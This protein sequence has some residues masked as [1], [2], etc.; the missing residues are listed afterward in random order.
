MSVSSYR[1]VCVEK[2]SINS[3]ALNENP[4][5]KHQRMLVAG[6]VS[7]SATGTRFKN[8][9]QYFW[10]TMNHVPGRAGRNSNILLSPV[11]LSAGARILLKDTTIMP[12]LLGLPALLTMLFTPVMELRLVRRADPPLHTSNGSAV[13]KSC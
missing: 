11:C 2:C 9:N 7:V 5:Y 8:T 3:L 4:H 10:L 13:R 6:S 1:T 12:D